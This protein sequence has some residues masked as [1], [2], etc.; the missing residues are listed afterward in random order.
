MKFAIAGLGN[1]A[2]NRVMPAIYATGN[3]ITSI[4]SRNIDK[5]RKEGMKYNA[6]PYDNLDLML[7]SG[8]FE[9][10]Y[11]ASPNFLHYSQAKSALLSGKHVLLEKQMTLDSGEA[12]ELVNL[13]E[14]KG[15]KLALGF[16]MRFHP[17]VADVKNII[18]SGDLGD[19][20]YA[21]GFW[22]Y[23]SSRSYDNPDNKWWSEDEKV[24]GG[25]VMATGVHVLD[26]M[27]Y[28]F[29]GA[30][31]RV[32]SFRNPKGV[33]I[34]LTEHISLQY[35]STIVDVISSR[36]MSGKSNHLSIHGS[37]GSL[38]VMNLFST[39]VES[40]MIRDGKK[41]KSYRGVDVYREEVKSFV[42]YVDNNSSNIAK[43][44]DGYNV[45]RIVEEAFR[46]DSGNDGSN[47][48]L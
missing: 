46:L 44:S 29:E 17:A 42:Q 40:D 47:L 22:C 8:D 26:T 7:E 27:N 28:I 18:K 39:T 14:E 10:V 21:S 31:D 11:I 30:P 37:K 6:A 43:G 5:A 25:S 16:H 4:Y 12:K 9:A 32:N 34:E 23:Q 33:V 19:I 13:A 38:T 36:A 15:L 3:Q 20:S 35:S 24:G 2:I 41:V 48:G 45:V 1:H